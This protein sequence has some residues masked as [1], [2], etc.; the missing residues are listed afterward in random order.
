M[1]GQLDF[2][3]ALMVET[4]RRTRRDQP[5][6]TRPDGEMRNRRLV[7]DAWQRWLI[8]W[9]LRHHLIELPDIVLPRVAGKW[10][11]QGDQRLHPSR[12]VARIFA[13]EEPA[14][15]PADN[16]DRPVVAKA[17]DPL[18]QLVQRV[19]SG[20]EIETLLPAVDPETRPSQFAAKREGRLVAAQEAGNDQ[21]RL[22]VERPARAAL[23]ERAE[24]PSEVPGNLAPIAAGRRRIVPRPPVLRRNVPAQRNSLPIKPCMARGSLT[25]PSA[26]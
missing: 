9:M 12:I 10:R 13:A 20:A 25:R 16:D 1:A 24:H 2:L 22:A 4:A 23:A 5:V 18:A 26:V 15:A 8:D 14:E 6:A 21:H 19:R 3:V 7:R 17:V 11:T